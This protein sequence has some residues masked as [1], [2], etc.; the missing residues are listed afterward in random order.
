M[1][2][3]TQVCGQWVPKHPTG[4]W[5]GLAAERRCCLEAVLETGTQHAAR[6]RGAEPYRHRR[7]ITSA[8]S[9]RGRT[10]V[11][12]FLK[13]QPT[14]FHEAVA[15]AMYTYQRDKVV[16]TRGNN[17]VDLVLINQPFSLS[18]L[19]VEPPFSSSDHNSVNFKVIRQFYSWYLW[20]AF[21]TIWTM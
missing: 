20:H 13:S 9:D 12:T 8:V 2:R 17:L 3:V 10:S 21:C 7:V 6:Y 5:K 1:W 14:N 4:Y 15:V 11:Y 19:S 16:T 18:A